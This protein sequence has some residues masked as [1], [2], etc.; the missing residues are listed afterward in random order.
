M[1]KAENGNTV[2]VH[3]KGT[4]PDG[5]LFASSYDRN[6]PFELTLGT[7]MAIVGFEKA[8]VGL[9][10]GQTIN[11]TL[12]PE[13]AYG[14]SLDEMK[15]EIPRAKLPQDLDPQVGMILEL[16]AGEDSLTATITSVDEENV[17]LDG[18]HPLAGET[19]QFSIELLE[20]LS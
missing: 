6:E 20:I 19:L 16:Q 8:I 14:E 3:Y 4:L 15:V 7:G 1:P 12:A 17:L 11:V 2:K 5:T 18:N 13:E 10:V 9:E